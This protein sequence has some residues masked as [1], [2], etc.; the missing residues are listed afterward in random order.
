VSIQNF[1]TSFIHH[2]F[3]QNFETPLIL[4]AKGRNYIVQELLLGRG[5]DVTRADVTGMTAMHYESGHGDAEAVKLLLAHSADPNARDMVRSKFKQYI[6]AMHPSA[7]CSL[8]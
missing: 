4:A 5:A 3:N 6:K 8:R 1:E 2:F 7:C